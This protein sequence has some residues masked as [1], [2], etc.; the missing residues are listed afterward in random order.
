MEVGPLGRFIVNYAAG[1]EQVVDLTNRCLKKL[2]A[3]KD[4]LF[5]VIGRILARS[6]EA[7]LVS[8]WKSDFYNKLVSNIKGGE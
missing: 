2:N 8:E 5:S 4:V 3:D 7:T 6:M 1:N